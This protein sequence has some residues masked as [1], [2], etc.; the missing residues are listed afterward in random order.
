MDSLL[1]SLAISLSNQ[2]LPE[3][4]VPDGDTPQ[5]QINSLIFLTLPGQTSCS[6]PLA[7]DDIQLELHGITG[8]L[9]LYLSL[10][11]PSIQAGGTRFL[12]MVEIQLLCVKYYLF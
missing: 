12:L 9:K 8:F 1:S 3:T 2:R 7:G 11:F 4:F 6:E 10:W 5:H